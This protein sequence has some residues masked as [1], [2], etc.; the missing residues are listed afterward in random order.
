MTGDNMRIA[1]DRLIN[2]KETVKDP[3]SDNNYAFGPVKIDYSN[4]SYCNSC[5]EN[6]FTGAISIENGK[7]EY[8]VNKCV[9]CRRCISACPNQAI[10]ATH[11]YKLSQLI[12]NPDEMR[13]KIFSIYKRSFVLRSVDCG[14]CNACMSELSALNNTYYD[15]SRYG[16]TFAA[17]PRHA[18]GIIVTGPVA[19]NMKHAL[20]KTYCAMA[21]PR[22]V[23]A[24]GTCTY[25]NGVYKDGYSV[26]ESLSEIL[27]VD[28]F[29]PG[30]P[31]SPQAIIYGLFLLLEKL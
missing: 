2:K 10:T 21:E 20:L 13:K 4:C 16:I 5:A 6:C 11:N 7:I 14:S 1:W 31:P 30:C 29:I 3:I 15:I 18:D 8:D 25:E 26:K 23:I 9:F 24:C 28:L 12:N 19:I 17:S 27:P 22:I